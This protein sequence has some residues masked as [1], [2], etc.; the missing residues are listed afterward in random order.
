MQNKHGADPRKSATEPAL[1]II[2]RRLREIMAEPVD[3]QGRLDR[4]VR[5]IAGLMV[6]E[7][8]SIYIRRQDGS[9]ELFA[10]EG[11]NPG[12]VHNTFMRRGE[13]LVGRCAELAQP[14]NEPDA[15]SH[16][17]F[18]YRPETGE[19][20]YHSLLAVPILRAGDVMGVLV[21]QNKTKREYSEEDVEVLETTAMVLAEHLVSGDVAGVNSASEFSRATGHVVKG[22]AMSEGLALG[23]VVVHESRVIVTELRSE[24][25][26]AESRRL[27]AAVDELQA[28]LDELLEQG[29]LA[30]SGEHREVFEAYRMFAHDRGWLRRMKE[31]IKGGLTAEAA[32]E[33]VQND[34]RARLLGQPD[35]Y[36]RDRLRDLD[37]LS[38]RLLRVLS[39][40]SRL[41]SATGALPTDAVVVARSM[42]PADLLDYDR[43]RIKGL[44]IEDA[45]SQSHVAIVAKAMGL[46]AIGGA[47]GVVERVDAG[48]PIIVDATTGE[49][50]IRPSSG[51]IASYADQARFQ[52]RKQRKYRAMKDTSPVTRDGERISLHI[53]AGLLVDMP[54][55]DASGADGIG[56]FRTELQFMVSRTLPRLER[57]RQMYRSILEQAGRRP[58][59]FRLL[60]VGGDKSLPYLRQ[61]HEEN[62]ALGWRAIRM[63][64]DR[65]GL[66][67]TQ[68]R[69]MLRAGAGRDLRLLLP[70]ITEVS[71]IDAAKSLIE[72][73]RELM[74]QRGREEPAQVRI[75]VMIEVPALLYDIDSVLPRVDFAS[76]GSNDLMQYLFAADRGNDRVARRYDPLSLPALR[77]LSTIVAASKRHGKAVTLCGEMAGRPIEAMALLGL[78]FRSLSMSA[79]SIGPVKSMLLGLDSAALSARLRG[80]L[81]TSHSGV[82]VRAELRRFAATSGIEL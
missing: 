42:G 68:V 53:N 54:Q 46:A 19:E 4:I 61:P 59:V 78:G 28:T 2:M 44:V 10:T 43:T 82:D 37:E 17:A 40:N 32:V 9:L 75:G 51:V 69:A 58:V 12:A 65:P 67:R 30:G 3:G 64:L 71:E 16:P 36:L 38:D 5:Q 77:A 25:P 74:R 33:R 66:M 70:M 6:S 49:V 81:E 13:G 73:E 8:C 35:T 72:R 39:G 31:A 29:D 7:V 62:P 14:I 41:K 79:S 76:V 45:A 27:E 60:D 24:D 55:L 1:R 18:S 80:L 22:H 52:A 23:H 15:Q 56:L 21:V 11:L 20:I 34:T 47:R 57:Q 63:S 26:E 50:H 48:D